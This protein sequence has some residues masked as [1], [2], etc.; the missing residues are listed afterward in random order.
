MEE[1]T[2]PYENHNG[3]HLYVLGH[4]GVVIYAGG[5]GVYT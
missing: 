3:T 5:G 4:N 2:V 1:F